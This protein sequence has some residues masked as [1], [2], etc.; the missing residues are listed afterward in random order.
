MSSIVPIAQQ[1][2]RIVGGE[3]QWYEG[4]AFTINW[5]IHLSEDEHPL[6]FQE[7]DVLVWNF[8]P[9]Y[10]PATPVHT[11]T[12][13]YEDI[14]EDTVTLYFDRAISKKFKAGSY[15]YCVKFFARDGRTVTL[16]ARNRI[17]V[18]ACH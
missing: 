11:F 15:T 6:E 1:S 7:G 17:R 2:P 5:T 10:C 8:F 14:V 9:S 18:I 4:D 13:Q 16:N 12:F 3:I